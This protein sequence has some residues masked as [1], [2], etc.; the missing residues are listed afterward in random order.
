MSAFIGKGIVRVAPVDPVTAALKGGYID[1]GEVENYEPGAEV[2]S[3]EKRTSRDVSNAL[4]AYVETQINSSLNITLVE[5]NTANLALIVRGEKVTKNS[6]TVTDEVLHDADEY[7]VV[8]D[9]VLYTKYPITSITNI[10]DSNGTPAT[11]TGSK[12]ERVTGSQFG[13][14]MLDVAGYTQPFTVTYVRQAHDI[15]KILEA[16]VKNYRVVIENINLVDGEVQM[17][18]Y[19]NCRLSPS[20]R[21]GLITEE[22]ASYPLEGRAL[23]VPGFDSDADLGKYGRII[24]GYVAS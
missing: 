6:A 24:R 18:E 16:D 17:I 9:D 2:Q 4:I 5:P 12:Y 11:V 23:A 10:K 3:L 21:F 22:F 15:V 19:Y 7:T 14:R 13:I 8:D 1:L 20:A